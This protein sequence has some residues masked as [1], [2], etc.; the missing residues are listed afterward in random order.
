MNQGDAMALLRQSGNLVFTTKEFSAL[1]G[2]SLSFASQMLGRL[3]AKKRIIHLCRSLWA[4]VESPQFN[5]YQV[6]P[7][8]TRPHPAALS[9]LTAMHLHGMIEQIP[10][11]VDVVSTAKTKKVKTPVADYSIHQLRP[12]FFTGYQ[13]YRGKGNFL[14]ASPEKALVDSIYFSMRK[15]KR[16]SVF[17][18]LHLPK[19]FSRKKARQWAEKI[20]Y[21][22]LR[23]SVQLR[24]EEVLSNRK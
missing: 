24:L 18:E 7:Y 23:K 17:P 14:I 22:K 15:G 10:Q 16:F 19:S 20:S 2:I 9:M 6:V 8:L 5:T 13:F 3:G 4:D 21:P 11:V 12:D 1:G